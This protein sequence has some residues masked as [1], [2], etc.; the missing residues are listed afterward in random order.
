MPNRG[1]ESFA[2]GLLLILI[3]W[4]PAALLLGFGTGILFVVVLALTSLACVYSMLP[5]LS[6]ARRRRIGHRR[7][8]ERRLDEL[9][10]RKEVAQRLPHRV[11]ECRLLSAKLSD[12]QFAALLRRL[13][14]GA[15]I[16]IHD[17]GIP[18]V[19]VPP[20][21]ET[22]FEPVRVDAPTPEVR[23]LANE[24]LEC[25]RETAADFEPSRWRITWR[26]L[27]LVFRSILVGVGCILVV[28]IMFGRFLRGPW[29]FDVS[30]FI[31][32]LLAG[33]AR[34]LL[35]HRRE[36]FVIPGGIVV[37]GYHVWSRRQRIHPVFAHAARLVIDLRKERAWVDDG[38][39]LHQFRCDPRC[40]W[41]LLA[42]WISR[43]RRPGL[44]ELR[45]FFGP[46]AAI[47]EPSTDS[48]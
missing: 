16:V 47:L 15:V 30:A 48:G 45:A 39:K 2:F 20:V 18:S 25:E 26:G 7:L 46:D 37:R 29:Y 24:L 17:R 9:V 23:G 11:L 4:L 32:V 21:T 22:F 19:A 5:R 40:A 33:S 41:A 27:G 34:L 12:S 14:V 1:P 44:D 31:G 13:P 36:H 3:F 8:R 43:A 6:S 42:A 10:A 38:E 35:P 28:Q